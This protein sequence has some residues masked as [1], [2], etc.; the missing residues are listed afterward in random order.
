MLAALCKRTKL[1]A[2]LGGTFFIATVF[3]LI[4]VNNA[5]AFDM[6][7]GKKLYNEY[8]ASCHGADGRPPFPG[9]PDFSMRQ[10]LITTDN[11]L[12]KIIVEGVGIMPGY[13]GII[14]DEG[15]RDVIAFMRFN[16]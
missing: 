12:Y 14:R 15:I 11:A 4:Y 8:C 16:F 2:L 5:A 10:G 6:N 13:R 1:S 3:T 7:N 9:T